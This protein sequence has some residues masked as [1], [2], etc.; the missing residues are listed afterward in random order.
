MGFKKVGVFF[1]GLS[2]E[3]EVSLLSGRAVAA[4]L[5]RSGFDVVEI[6][7]NR[8][9]DLRL[10]ESGVEAVFIALH[11]RLGEDGT[12]QGLLE[13]R[14]IPYTGSGVTASAVA[15][16]KHL[17][18][19]LLAASNVPVADGMLLHHKDERKLPSRWSLPVV[20]KPAAEGSSVGVS[21]A[22]TDAELAAGLDKA[23]QMS[24]RVLVEKFVAGKE[25]QV[26]ILDEKIL[27]S[28]EIEPIGEFYDYEAKYTKGG[29]VHHLPP[30]ISNELNARC[31]TLAKQA[32]DAVGCAGLAR[33][34]LI[35]PKEGTPVVLEINTIPG[36]TELSLAPEIAAYAGIS[37]DELVTLIMNS[38]RLHGQ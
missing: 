10:R 1:G 18:R 31:C 7:V 19:T 9:V 26:A 35:A 5:R 22:K 3:R 27:G 24:K 20:V 15:M 29:A 14:G 8:E 36:M 4:G 30:R 28:I 11:G 34:D 21:I 16:D 25:V 12:V 13:M 2:S 37:F 17:T 23:F 33:I 6:D 38:A 32:Y